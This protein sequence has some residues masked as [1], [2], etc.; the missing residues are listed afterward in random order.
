[1][2]GAGALLDTGAVIGLL[3]LDA[4]RP[5]LIEAIR[6]EGGTVVPA[7]S[8]VTLGELAAGVRSAR[9]AA[10]RTARQRSLDIV[11][12]P[13]RPRR[14]SVLPIDRATWQSFGDI[15]AALTRQ[16][17]HNDK[18]ITAA[19]RATGRLLVTQDEDLA[20]RAGAIA[21]VRVLLVPRQP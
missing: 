10:S 5:Q 16:V 4:D 3:E 14:L 12:A 15:S 17:G 20:Q 21:D 7:I 9:D 6:V 18:W 11:D 8:V 1:M 13:H 2:T 19:A